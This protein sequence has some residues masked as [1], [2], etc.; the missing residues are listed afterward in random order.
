[1]PQEASSGCTL[2]WVGDEVSHL[3][4]LV[5][6]SVDGCTIKHKHSRASEEAKMLFLLTKSRE[7]TGTMDRSGCSGEELQI[8]AL[9]RAN[10]KTDRLDPRMRQY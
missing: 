2:F 4:K 9:G 1:M 7:T 5:S 10:K 8:E 3:R 6:V